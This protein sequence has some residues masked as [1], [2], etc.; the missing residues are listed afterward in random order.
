MEF[1]LQLPKILF[2][3]SCSLSPKTPTNGVLEQGLTWVRV[4]CEITW[5][6]VDLGAN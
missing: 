2:S 4:G 1:S 6:R 5:V 3:D